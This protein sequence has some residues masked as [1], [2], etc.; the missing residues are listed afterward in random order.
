MDRYLN[1]ESYNIPMGTRLLED[2][3]SICSSINEQIDEQIDFI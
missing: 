1:N 3:V 2:K